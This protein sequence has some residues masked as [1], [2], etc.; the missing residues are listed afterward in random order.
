MSKTQKKF[1]LGI[2]C[3]S[4][5]GLYF[6]S[7]KSI[8]TF[9]IVNQYLFAKELNLYQRYKGGSALITGSTSGLGKE[10]AMQFAKRGFNIVQVARNDEKLENTKNEILEANSKIKVHNIQF[11]FDQP[12]TEEAYSGLKSELENLD[13][14][15]V[16]V[17]N[18]GAMSPGKF[19]SMDL[20]QANTMI[21]V[22]CIPQLF[23]TR[24]LLPKMIQRANS[25]KRCAILNLSSVATDTK[26]PSMGVY[27]A[28]KVYNKNLSDVLD[29]EVNDKNIDVLCVQPGP[30]VSNMIK[31]LGPCII[32]PKDHVSSVLSHLGQYRSTYGHY[33]HMVYISLIRYQ[34]FKS[35]YQRNK[36]ALT[37]LQ[38]KP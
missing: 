31:V 30:T 33:K 19:D 14:V 12:Y 7:K 6:L 34:W 35:Y 15:S 16:L 10:Y 5:L 1:P 23:F 11:D 28:T 36:K 21:Q 9:K 32:Y 13:D 27:S 20:I 29:K 8:E 3:L 18:V 25:D 26:A 24:T 37:K 22:N 4:A 17:N 38:G 2:I